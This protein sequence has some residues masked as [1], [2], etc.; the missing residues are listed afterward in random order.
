MLR[1]VAYRRGEARDARG[2]GV[3]R[4]GWWGGVRGDRGSC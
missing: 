3:Q 1:G 4:G 2:V